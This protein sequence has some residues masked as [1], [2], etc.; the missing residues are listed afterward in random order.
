[1]VDAAGG[2]SMPSCCRC[3]RMVLAPASVPRL[4]SSSR[5][6]RMRSVMGCWIALG[7]VWGRLER[8]SSASYPPSRWR[9]CRVRIQRVVTPKCSAASTWLMPVISMVSMMIFGAGLSAFVID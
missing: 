9:R 8:G 6:S 1:M 7:F 2:G 3:Q 4:V 5:S